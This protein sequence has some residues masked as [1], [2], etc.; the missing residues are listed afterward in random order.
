[1]KIIIKYDNKKID[2]IILINYSVTEAKYYAKQ[3]AK[4]Y[5]KPYTILLKC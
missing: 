2:E 5:E 1:M 3:I 4:K